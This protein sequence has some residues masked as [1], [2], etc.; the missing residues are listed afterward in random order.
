MSSGTDQFPRRSDGAVGVPHRADNVV[1]VHWHDTGRWFGTYGHDSLVT[2]NVDRLAAEGILLTRAHAAAPLC[3][4]SRGALLSGR[5]PHSNGLVGL[6]HQGFE[7]RPGVR[8]L[9]HVLTDAGWYS[10]LFGMQHETAQPATL[11][12]DEFDVSD[13]R[14]DWVVERAENWLRESVPLRGDKPF[15]LTAGFFETHRPYPPDQYHAADPGEVEVPPYLPDD[16]KVRADIAAFYGAITKAD[17]AVGR[18]LDTLQELGL[19]DTTWVVFFTDHGAPFPHAKS[20]L[21]D[22][23]TGIALM[24]RPPRSLGIE[25]R[26]YEGL[27]SG[28][29]LLPTLLDLLGVR[30]PPEVEGF[31]HAAALMVPSRA[32][33]PVRTAV[34]GEKTYHDAFDPIRAVRT[35]HFSYIENYA[36]RP[37]LELPLDIQDSASG[38][39][40]AAEASRPRAARE[41]YDLRADPWE[42]A[43]LLDDAEDDDALMLADGLALVLHEWRERTGDVVPSLFAGTRIL[44]DC[45]EAFAAT[46][47]F[48]PTSR[49]PLGLHRGVWPVA[50]DAAAA[51]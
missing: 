3:S 48:R 36:D 41:L 30:V 50:S 22:A 13:S 38:R 7:Y 45:S 26:V 15:L 18:L 34:F 49:S 43:N 51:R 29:D 47:A 24:L 19:D 1:L 10:A 20:T 16:A 28:V 14:C 44:V 39:A 21:Y 5:Y 32:G 33:E 23:G 40:V 31:S 4:P 37:L 42:L 46:C 2:P 12:F 9:F 8:T 17:A 6:A 25:P 35:A 27:C 11:G